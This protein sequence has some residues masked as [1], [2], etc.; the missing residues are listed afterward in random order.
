[1]GTHEVYSERSWLNR[2]KVVHSDGSKLKSSLKQLYCLRSVTSPY[3]ENRDKQ[4][5]VVVKGNE[6]L[7]E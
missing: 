3:C 4:Y 5:R 1:M 6:A 7:K 2:S